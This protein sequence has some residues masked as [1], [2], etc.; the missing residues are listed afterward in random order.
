MYDAVVTFVTFDTSEPDGEVRAATPMDPVVTK[1]YRIEFEG[2]EDFMQWLTNASTD[3]AL[4][5]EQLGAIKP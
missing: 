2:E 4:A 3:G 1:V 5:S